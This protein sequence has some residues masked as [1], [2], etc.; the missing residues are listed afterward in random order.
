MI[1]SNYN[2]Y[3]KNQDF[4]SSPKYLLGPKEWQKLVIILNSFDYNIS[5]FK[6]NIENQEYIWKLMISIQK[7]L[8]IKILKIVR[9]NARL[10]F[11][12]E[13]PDKIGKIN[14]SL[15]RINFLF[16]KD[17]YKEQ[18]SSFYGFQHFLSYINNCFGNLT[19]FIN[20]IK[21]IKNMFCFYDN[22]QDQILIDNFNYLQDIKLPVKGY[23]DL[24]FSLISLLKRFD[25]LLPLICNPVI[26][27]ELL[28]ELQK[29]KNSYIIKYQRNH[30]LY[31]KKLK[32]FYKQ[33][34]SQPEFRIIDY[35]TKNTKFS[36]SNQKYLNHLIQF[37]PELCEEDNLENLLQ[38]Q[39]RCKCEYAIGDTIPGIE[40]IKP[41]L[42][43]EMRNLISEINIV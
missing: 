15:F 35:I 20:E 4:S 29:F 34:F 10:C 26:F 37:F 2:S 43:L 30:N 5:N 31:Q 12:L 25:N 14:Q 42:V 22:Q 39:T 38:D 1:K 27:T 19:F 13:Q 41:K 23:E 33:L 36:G 8:N 16:E 32:Q 17:I 11:I 7:Y 6:R 40:K 18:Y 3:K 21:I 9:K 28:S 24:K